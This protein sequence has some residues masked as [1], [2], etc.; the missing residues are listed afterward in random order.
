LT[1]AAMIGGTAYVAGKAGQRAAQQQADEAQQEQSQEE[2]PEEL[3]AAQAGGGA[4]GDAAPAAAQSDD[5][6]AK[7][8]ELKGLADSGALTDEEFQAAKAKLLA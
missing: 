1:R 5:L 8:T 2:R 4:S 7:L 6:V 3:E